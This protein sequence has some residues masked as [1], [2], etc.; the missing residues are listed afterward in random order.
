VETAAGS[1]ALRVNQRVPAGQ[2]APFVSL[3]VFELS[4]GGGTVEIVGSPDAGGYV[5]ADAVQWLPMD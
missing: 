2:H 1:A 4:D 3:G 5:T